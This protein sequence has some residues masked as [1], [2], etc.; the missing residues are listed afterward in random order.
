MFIPGYS[1]PQML[2]DLFFPFE[3]PS[4]FDIFQSQVNNDTVCYYG[5]LIECPYN[6]KLHS[7]LLDGRIMSNLTDFETKSR[8]TLRQDENLGQYRRKYAHCPRFLFDRGK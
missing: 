2:R 5:A 3:T 6:I 4:A 8:R 7:S 1:P